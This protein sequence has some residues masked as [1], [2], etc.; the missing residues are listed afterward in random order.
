[1]A[2]VFYMK[3]SWTVIVVNSTVYYLSSIKNYVVESRIVNLKCLTINFILYLEIFQKRNVFL[4]E[5]NPLCQLKTSTLERRTAAKSAAA[6][7]SCVKERQLEGWTWWLWCRPTSSGYWRR[8]D[9]AWR[10]ASIRTYRTKI[11]RIRNTGNGFKF[12]TL[13]LDAPCVYYLD[14]R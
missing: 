13:I 2:L 11:S 4:V 12:N 5:D 1:M 10:C 9:P 8:R 14:H 6:A 7:D 3:G